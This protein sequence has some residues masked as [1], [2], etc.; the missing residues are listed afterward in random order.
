[1][2]DKR[3]EKTIEKA[4]I[5][6]FVAFGDGGTAILLMQ[7][8]PQG[9][10][11]FSVNPH[12]ECR[13]CVRISRYNDYTQFPDVD[14]LQGLKKPMGIQ[15]MLSHLNKHY[16]ERIPSILDRY[17]YSKK[18]EGT[19]ATLLLEYV[20][21]N[22]NMDKTLYIK[23]SMEDGRFEYVFAKKILSASGVLDNNMLI[24]RLEEIYYLGNKFRL[25]IRVDSP[26]TVRD[27]IDSI[28]DS[29]L[30]EGSISDFLQKKVGVY[31]REAYNTVMKILSNW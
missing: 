8:A 27:M 5:W 10:I 22:F 29:S 19:R 20:S 13:D 31:P 2:N 21:D 16:G 24:L 26:Y 23:R 1:M 28:V 17:Y 9:H 25:S 18:S 30:V 7:K 14:K 11:I 15:S 3:L 6:E 12:R 4:K